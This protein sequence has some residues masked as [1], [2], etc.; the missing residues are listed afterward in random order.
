MLVSPL[1]ISDE[2]RLTL[3]TWTRSSVVS[4]G[5]AERAA[6]VLACADGSGT[7]EAARGLGC[8]GRRS[9]SGGT[10]TPRRASRD[11]TTSHV[12]A[13]PR[14]WTTRPSSR[15]PS[16]RPRAPRV[17]H[18]STRLLAGR[19]ASATPRS[20][21]PAPVPRSAV[22]PGD[23]QVS[24][25]PE[26][27]AKVR[28]VVGL[29]LAPPEKAI[30]LCVDEKSQIQALDR[31]APILPLRPGLPERAT[32]D[33]KRNGTTTLFAALEVATGRVTDQCYDRHGKAESEPVKSRETP[34]SSFH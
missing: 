28:D 12:P 3:T 14:R 17:T 19:W 1:T 30:V 2:D 26:L 23:L 31:T 25:D 4:A 18:W 16:S 7:S 27:E 24:T 13:G 15:P 5:R 9:S 20:P 34:E 22:A 11:S 10:G 32:H 21:V 6:I 33:Y 29:Y 8:H